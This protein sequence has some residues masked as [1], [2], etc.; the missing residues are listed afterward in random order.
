MYA[1]PDL[2]ARILIPPFEHHLKYDLSGYPDF[3]IG[4]PISLFGRILTITDVFDALTSPRI[5]RPIALSPD[6]ALGLMM[7]KAGKD[8]DPIL[9]KVFM[10]MLG[11]DGKTI[12][13]F[14]GYWRDERTFVEEQNFD[15]SSDAQFFTV[16]YVF[17]GKKVLF[18]VDS[19]MGLFPTINGTLEIIE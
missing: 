14:R 2:K 12:M 11:A 6:R 15:L 9:L 16:T 7:K 13:P 18:T 17:D 19:S 3:N 4:K 8:F 5:Y 1:S 10:N